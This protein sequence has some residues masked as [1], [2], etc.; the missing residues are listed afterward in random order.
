MIPK[1][2]R[3]GLSTFASL[4]RDMKPA[5]ESLRRLAD[6]LNDLIA[7][8][9]APSQETRP[10]TTAPGGPAGLRGTLAK[11][12]RMLDGLNAFFGSQENQANL[13]KSLRELAKAAGS[14]REAM[15]AVKA[16]A[17]AA[18][19]TVKDVSQVV[20]DSGRRLSDLTEKLIADAEKISDVMA[21]VS[22][23]LAKIDSGSG[24]AGRLINDP[25]LYQNL[26][27]ATRQ[28]VK[29]LEDFRLLLKA[30]NKGGVPIKLK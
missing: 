28:M 15:A 22:G 16:F 4:G 19:K 7:P 20:D 29:L 26:F 12:D 24:T 13:K 10:S 23:L 3:D 14:A 21:G 11:I 27:E 17:T 9:T 6:S 25:K 1:E 18:R 8:P 5:M 30:W 2:L